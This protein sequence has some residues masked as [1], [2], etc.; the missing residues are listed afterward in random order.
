GG[1][2]GAAGGAG[3]TP[4]SVW[5]LGALAGG[6]LSSSPEQPGN[7]AIRTAQEAPRTT[8][9]ERMSYNVGSI[10]QLKRNDPPSPSTRDPRRP[11]PPPLLRAPGA[12][13]PHLAS[14]RSRPKVLMRC[15][16]PIE[17]TRR[18]IDKTPRRAC[19]EERCAPP[20]SSRRELSRPG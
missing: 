9:G 6:G 7:T 3:P 1:A 2:A 11:P 12:D 18:A 4:G 16:G 13:H 5:G 14:A 10:I 17:P 15:L 8:R 20:A 19:S